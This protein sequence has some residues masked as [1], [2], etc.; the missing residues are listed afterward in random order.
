[1]GEYVWMQVLKVIGKGD[2]AWAI[3]KQ[4]KR[5]HVEIID[6]NYPKGTIKRGY[7]ILVCLSETLPTY[8]VDYGFGMFQ[9]RC[10]VC[11]KIT[12]VIRKEETWLT[13]GGTFCY[14]C[15]MKLAQEK[16]REETR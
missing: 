13:P 7:Y 12:E 15:H 10:D 11:G 16:K 1:M 5:Y 3:D 4:G 8:A 2:F 6:V 9:G 14:Q